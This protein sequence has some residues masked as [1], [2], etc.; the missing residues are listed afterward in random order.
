MTDHI[1]LTEQ[2]KIALTYADE[3]S[4]RARSI[5]F[6]LQLAV[7]L[8]LAGLW[9]Q[10]ESNWIQLRIQ[11]ASKAV[12]MLTCA[13]QKIGYAPD[14]NDP[15]K[16]AQI[17][18][19]RNQKKVSEMT[20][21]EMADFLS[22]RAAAQ[23]EADEDEKV[24]REHSPQYVNKYFDRKYRDQE[25]AKTR[26]YLASFG[27]SP[28]LAKKNLE[29]LHQLRNNHVLGLGVPVLGIVFDVNDLSLLAAITFSI[30]LSWLHFSLRREKKNVKKVFYIARRAD[31]AQHKEGGYNK[32]EN[33]EVAYDLLAM[34][35]VFTIPPGSDP[36]SRNVHSH[37]WIRVP[38][39]I[40]WTAVIAEAIVLINDRITMAQGDIFNPLISY[41][42]TAIATYLFAYILYRTVTC[43]KLIR[44]EYDEWI[45]AHNQCKLNPIENAKKRGKWRERL[46][47]AEPELTTV[48][49]FVLA[50]IHS[51][52]DWFA[53]IHDRPHW[54]Q[55]LDGVQWLGNMMIAVAILL[56][57]ATF[58]HKVKMAISLACSLLALTAGDVIWH[59][60]K[61]IS[62]AQPTGFVEYMDGLY[63][64]PL[65]IIGIV[66]FLSK[67]RKLERKD[68][69]EPPPPTSPVSSNPSDEGKA[70]AVVAS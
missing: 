37:L 48:L 44:K 5:I 17:F 28:D 29:A 19:Y 47:K 32:F 45:T 70:K 54:F 3:S 25:D 56:C 69:T 2:L 11:R 40:M 22:C 8:V 16:T 34:T 27:F 20:S 13:P 55:L 64:S 33:L 35:Q 65:L 46:K 15:E 59:F 4:K 23:A 67:A 61:V 52:D 43:F 68:N 58:F 38:T 50:V 12:R 21:E 53:T 60:L 26:D 6:L 1:R 62:Y 9:Q 30:L 24:I 66:I 39:L 41:A 10:T 31:L 18:Q 14:P 57:V 49:V 36:K 63:T 7:V 51:F 42:E